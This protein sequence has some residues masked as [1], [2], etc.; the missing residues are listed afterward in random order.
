M[1]QMGFAVAEQ[2]TQADLQPAA[3]LLSLYV[4]PAYRQQGIGT[5]LVNHLQQLVGKPLAR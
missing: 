1:V 3:E 2:F 5:L 4:L